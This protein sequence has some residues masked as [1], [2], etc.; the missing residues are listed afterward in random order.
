ML[1][2]AR[3]LEQ[4]RC[5]HSQSRRARWRSVWSSLGLQDDTRVVPCD[6]PAEERCRGVNN[7]D[8]APRII[9][10]C[11]DPQ[12]RARCYTA[13]SEN[14]CGEVYYAGLPPIVAQLICSM[15]TVL[16]SIVTFQVSRVA[17]APTGISRWGRVV[18]RAT[19]RCSAPCK[20]PVWKPCLAM[21]DRWLRFVRTIGVSIFLVLFNLFVFFVNVDVVLA[22]WDVV[23]ESD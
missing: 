13:F 19:R 21:H 15:C 7:T 4:R 23:S 1:A 11:P 3:V 9:D 18:P 6:P 5:T 2:Q 22:V 12:D 8:A 16:D 14:G 20:P 10:S 17:H